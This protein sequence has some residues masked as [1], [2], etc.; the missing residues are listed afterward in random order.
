M[1]N[2]IVVVG[3]QWG[4]EG[5]GKITD[6]LGHGADVIVRFQGGNNAGHTIVFD[7]KKFALRLIPSGIFNQSKINVMGNGMVI[8][9]ISFKEEVESLH[10]ADV[11]TDNLYISDRAH[12][13]L[14]YHIALD[15]LYEELKGE[16]K[17][18]TTNNGI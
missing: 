8:N 6:Y 2:N 11:K 3:T 13:T 14:P 4:D 18:G 10:K 16:N 15:K 12:I 1:T 17:V 7:N 5:K 9:P